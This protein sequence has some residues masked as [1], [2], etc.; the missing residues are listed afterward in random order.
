MKQFFFAILLITLSAGCGG[1]ELTFEE[2]RMQADFEIP[3]GLNTIEA[4]FFVIREVPTFYQQNLNA[5]GIDPSNVTNISSAN[6]RL[7]QI[8]NQVDLD[9]ISS[10][11]IDAISRKDNSLRAEMFYNEQ[12]PFTQGPELRML[13]SS[14]ELSEIMKDD[15]ID[16]EVRLTFRSFST[17]KTECRLDIGY[18]IFFEN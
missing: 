13:S 9:F 3:V 17:V 4:H 18:A 11:T 5:R 2:V 16:L 15:L 8:F 7:L 1:D 10:I 12:I 14:S 6:G